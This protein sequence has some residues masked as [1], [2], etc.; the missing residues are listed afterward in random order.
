MTTVQ[1]S[2]YT[3]PLYE[4]GTE[5]TFKIRGAATTQ[6]TYYLGD[7]HSMPKVG[8]TAYKQVYAYNSSTGAYERLSGTFYKGTGENVRYYEWVEKAADAGELY[9]YSAPVT[10]KVQPE[11]AITVTLYKKGASY[12]GGLYTDYNGSSAKNAKLETKDVTALTI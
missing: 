12:S 7:G 5:Q 4:E 11:K 9:L 6:T 2:E 1:G 10:V 3:D 8:S